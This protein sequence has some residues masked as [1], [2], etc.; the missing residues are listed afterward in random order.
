MPS[1][2]MT[3]GKMMMTK[4]MMIIIIITHLIIIKTILTFFKGHSNS[5]MN[6]PKRG[7]FPNPNINLCGVMDEEQFLHQYYNANVSASGGYTTQDIEYLINL[8]KKIKDECRLDKIHAGPNFDCICGS[9]NLLK[10][11]ALLGS[12]KGHE[13]NT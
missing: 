7:N 13:V 11:V 8:C 4:M 2:T 3:P 10:W 12:C 6:L 1:W 9:T 5:F